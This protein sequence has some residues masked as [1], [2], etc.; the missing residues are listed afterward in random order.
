MSDKIIVNNLP[1]N[2]EEDAIYIINQSNPNSLTH[3]YFKYPCK[4]IPEI[5]KW[6]IN[7]FLKKTEAKSSV[8]DPFAGSGTTLLETVISEMNGFGGEID[9]V[10]KLIIKV[11]TTKLSDE[12]LKAIEDFTISIN[13]DL[14]E[15]SYS[16]NEIILPQINNLEHWF[17][18]DVLRKLGFI[19]YSITR[20]GNNN[21][22][23]F[24]LIC[25]ASIVKKVSNCDDIS[26]KPYVSNKIKKI[27]PDVAKTFIDVVNRNIASMRELNEFNLGKALIVGDAKKLDIENESIDVAIT[28]PPYINAFDYVRTLRLE[29]LWLNMATEEELREKKK[30]YLG[31]ESITVKKEQENLTI[32]K[33][34][35]LLQDY[36]E[37][38]FKTD[39]RRALIVKKF[40][41]DMSENLAEVKRVLKNNSCYVIVIGN[42]RIR[43]VDIESWRIL[44]DLALDL[45][46][47][48]VTHFG[49]EIQN[50][51]IRIPRGNKGG[52]ISIDH[53]LV[54]RKVE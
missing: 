39:P 52:K 41:E 20:I 51:Y 24:L 16:D 17:Q 7:T 28:S 4:F 11:K 27:I 2:V 37:E 18:E 1:E 32:L 30:L 48:Y 26:P 35:K 33:K 15:D 46:Y 8:L 25:M 43:N 13:N 38:V 44:K 19:Y 21:V 10:A 9:E 12:E 23:D 45:D 31:T 6:A 22:K 47:E 54:I 40:F 42:S 34:S 14:I 50:P 36:Y 53:I 5:P 3:N 49:Y 29:N